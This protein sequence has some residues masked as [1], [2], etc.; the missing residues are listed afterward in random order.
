MNDFDICCVGVLLLAVG[1]IFYCLCNY[2]FVAAYKIAYYEVILS[3]KDPDFDISDVKS[4]KKISD[5][6]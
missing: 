2:V 6:P 3:C 5:M 1:Y 4:M